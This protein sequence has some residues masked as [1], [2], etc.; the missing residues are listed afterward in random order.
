MAKITVEF[1]SNFLLRPVQF[2][3][4]IPNDPCTTWGPVEKKDYTKLKTLFVLHGYTGCAENWIP[5]ELLDKYQF[6]VVAPNGDLGF[7]VDGLSTGSAYGKFL[8]EE[9]VDYVRKTFHLAMTPEDTYL[10]GISM[11]GYGTIRNA[12]TYPEVF[13]KAAM[14][15]AAYIIHTIAGMQPGFVDTHANYEYYRNCFGDLNEVEKSRNNPE[16]LIDELLASG[17]KIPE[18]L[19]AI[20]TEDFL[21]EPNRGFHRFLEE[22][23][24][25][26]SYF[27]S[28]G[29]HDMVF[30]QEYTAKFIPML[31]AEQA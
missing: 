26:H 29:G 25:P 12:L 2:K 5:E 1:Y 20:G 6:A 18:I 16:V 30:W 23:N 8:C 13:G 31:F 27:E 7:W 11:G 3:V 21:L 4:F 10:M 17:K 14:L 19:M 24:V 15:S 28:T 9:L 22:R